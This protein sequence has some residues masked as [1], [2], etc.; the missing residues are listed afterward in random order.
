ML[1]RRSVSFRLLL[2]IFRNSCRQEK[3]QIGAVHKQLSLSL[4]AQTSRTLLY[5]RP[6]DLLMTYSA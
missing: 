5:I 3:H 4:Q 1:A 2:A 6:P